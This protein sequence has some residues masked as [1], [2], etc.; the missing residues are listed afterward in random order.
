MQL[1]QEAMKWK[2]R[3]AHL[4]ER[5]KQVMTHW[6]KQEAQWETQATQFEQAMERKDQAAQSEQE[7]ARLKEQVLQWKDR[8]V[9]LQTSYRSHV[10]KRVADADRSTVNDMITS[11]ERQVRNYS[12]GLTRKRTCDMDTVSSQCRELE[13]LAHRAKTAGDVIPTVIEGVFVLHLWHIWSIVSEEIRS[14][15]VDSK[16]TIDFLKVYDPESAEKLRRDILYFTSR[17]PRSK[18]VALKRSTELTKELLT[19]FGQIISPTFNDDERERHFKLLLKVTKT[20]LELDD[21]MQGMDPVIHPFIFDRGQLFDSTEMRA[22]P[23]YEG[24]LVECTIFPGF[25]YDH[26]DHKDHKSLIC[27]ALVVCSSDNSDL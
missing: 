2:D 21:I 9:T 1:G 11:L 7:I 19:F 24:D 23:G 3:A 14:N 4:E 25:K 12:L 20:A 26:E 27:Q 6:K 8:Y 10:E 16:K 13:Y 18:E 17:D 5:V 15:I 22:A